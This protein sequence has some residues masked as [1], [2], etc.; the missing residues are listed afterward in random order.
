MRSAVCEV[1]DI[2]FETNA[3]EP[4]IIDYPVLDLVHQVAR[5]CRGNAGKYCHWGGHHPGHH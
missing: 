2:D 5:L 1:E 3:K 4:L